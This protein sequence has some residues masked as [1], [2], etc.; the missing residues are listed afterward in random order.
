M[1]TATT[2]SEYIV[3]KCVNDSCPVSNLQLQKFLFY[4]QK[5]YLARGLVAFSDGIEAWQFGPVVPSVYYKFCGYGAMPITARYNTE[6]PAADKAV[7]DPLV[8]QK[9][10]LNPWDLVRETHNPTGAWAK[11]YD[12]GRG[13]RN[14]IDLSLIRTM[15]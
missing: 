6:I 4:I 13:N 5:D 7:I 15:G 3:T 12:E 10:M 1:M 8:E 9:R 11:V 2:I 14:L